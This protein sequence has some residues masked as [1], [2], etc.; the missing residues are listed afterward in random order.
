MECFKIIRS[1]KQEQKD[2][3]RYLYNHVRLQLPAGS[4]LSLIEDLKEQAIQWKSAWIASKLDL[5]GVRVLLAPSALSDTNFLL[6]VSVLT[7]QFN[8]I[9]KQSNVD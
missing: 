9:E 7:L 5:V 4:A 6:V 8:S 3:F 2:L 1:R